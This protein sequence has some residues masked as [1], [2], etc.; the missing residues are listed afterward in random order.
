V[1]IVFK[2]KKRRSREFRNSG[3]VIDLEEARQLR[4]QKREETAGKRKAQRSKSAVSKRKALKKNRRRLVYLAIFLGIAGIVAAS[5]INIV[6][7]RLT[8]ASTMKEQQELMDQKARLERIY[9]QVNSPEYIEQQ[10][11]QQLKMIKPGEILYVLPQKDNN[12][13]AT[14]GG[15][16]P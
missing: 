9:S 12:K 16:V 2:K 14:G 5:V 8:E 4:K 7:L 3:Q 6:S 1:G 13:K 15:I 10:A 11:R